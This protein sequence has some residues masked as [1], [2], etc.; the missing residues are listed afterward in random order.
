[1]ATLC[2]FISQVCL[3]C[4]LLSEG[5][6]GYKNT[7]TVVNIYLTTTIWCFMLIFIVSPYVSRLYLRWLHFWVKLKINDFNHL[8]RPGLIFTYIE[9]DYS[10]QRL[11]T[12][13][14]GKGIFWYQIAFI[15]SAL[16]HICSAM[17]RTVKISYYYWVTLNRRQSVPNKYR[18]DYQ[19]EY[20]LMYKC[21]SMCEYVT[22]AKEPTKPN[23]KTRTRCKTREWILE[24]K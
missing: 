2:K 21:S 5:K 18:A 12:Y 23:Q 19:W 8:T 17:F 24:S 6:N 4:E 13:S 16:L 14:I 11:T 15:T 9:R 22:N 3:C 7:N 1:M 10:V 20:A